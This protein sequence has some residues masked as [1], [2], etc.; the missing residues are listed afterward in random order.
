MEKHKATNQKGS[1]KE[2]SPVKKREKKKKEKKL[3]YNRKGIKTNLDK[4]KDNTKKVDK[5]LQNT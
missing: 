4:N 2:T 5:H 1:N 3:N